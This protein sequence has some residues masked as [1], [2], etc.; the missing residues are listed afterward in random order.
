MSKNQPQAL[1]IPANIE[2]V[3]LPLEEA[4]EA[5]IQHSKLIEALARAENSETTILDL[6]YHTFGRLV[7][8]ILP[9][10]NSV[11]IEVNYIRGFFFSKNWEHL[12]NIDLTDQDLSQSETA[13]I[14]MSIVYV[15][16][17]GAFD[18]EKLGVK[19][20]FC[21]NLS[22]NDVSSE[23]LNFFSAAI[24]DA[25]KPK[26]AL[27]GMLH[28]EHLGLTN[29]GI[30]PEDENVQHLRDLGVNV[31]IADTESAA[32]SFSGEDSYLYDDAP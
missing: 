18:E 24:A 1:I 32:A 12:R 5:D 27:P 29:C 8:Q 11:H 6:S 28:L 13:M 21:I 10:E 30:D 23:S 25:K 4:Q 20:L 16:G 19:Q 22:G 14:M 17:E 2:P 7:D 26:E 9:L 3:A 15:G 31:I